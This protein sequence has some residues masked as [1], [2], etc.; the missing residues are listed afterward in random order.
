MNAGYAETE[1]CFARSV[2][3]TISP[4]NEQVVI[5]VK[6]EVIDTVASVNTAIVIL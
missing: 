2:P 4:G 3:Q 1:I 6:A 5:V